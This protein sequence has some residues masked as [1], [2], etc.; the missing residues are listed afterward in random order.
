[1]RIGKK[2]AFTLIELLV[3][4]AIIALLVSILLPSLNRA[5]DLA[6]RVACL[7]NLRNMGLGM[8]MYQSDY[9]GLFPAR[10]VSL[11]GIRS[12]RGYVVCH[13][14]G[15]SVNYGQLLSGEYIESIESLYCPADHHFEDPYYEP[16]KATSANFGTPL[17]YGLIGSY[18]YLWR[19]DIGR[20]AGVVLGPPGDMYDASFF[21]LDNLV[22]NSGY[23]GNTAILCDNYIKCTG[24][25]WGD[26]VHG[27]GYS[28]LYADGHVNF[29]EDPDNDISE[30][31]PSSSN[32]FSWIWQLFDSNP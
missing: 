14:D 4:I 3:V 6:K 29:Y 12:V 27:D 2:K 28:V 20:V 32:T 5:K 18:I 11:P 19:F 9:D 21:S 13:A 30:A 25:T 8:V 23:P 16:L 17:G 7:S 15:T 1:M 31:S 10:V 24:G 22:G 26:E